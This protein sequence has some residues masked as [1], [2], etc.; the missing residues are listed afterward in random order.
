MEFKF[1]TG[2]CTQVHWKKVCIPDLY[3]NCHA[4]YL[5]EHDLPGLEAI[6]LRVT[7][8]QSGFDRLSSHTPVRGAP[9]SP[10]YVRFC[11]VP[12]PSIILSK[13][14]DVSFLLSTTD[15]I[16]NF[17]KETNFHQHTCFS[18]TRV[19]QVQFCSFSTA[20]TNIKL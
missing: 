12:E 2:S 8:Q 9:P 16:D 1:A 17:S 18:S 14:P 13:P 11:Y 10:G 5:T 19:L 7:M 3:E 4:P 6:A 20:Q 15:K